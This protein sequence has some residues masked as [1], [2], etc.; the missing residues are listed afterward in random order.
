MHGGPRPGA[1]RKRGST[2][3][4]TIARATRVKEVAKAIEQTIAGA[5]VGDSH[6]FLMTIYKDPNQ[7]LPLRL[8]AAKAAIGYEKPKLAAIEHSTDPDNPLET[9]TRVELVA[10]NVHSSG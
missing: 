8:D 2:G 7:P 5:F 3:E 9:V 10:P 1:G 6:D 4:K